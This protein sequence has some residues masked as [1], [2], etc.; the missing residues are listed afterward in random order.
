[1]MGRAQF[2]YSLRTGNRGL[3]TILVVE[4]RLVIIVL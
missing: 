1:M 2:V 3:L 4:D